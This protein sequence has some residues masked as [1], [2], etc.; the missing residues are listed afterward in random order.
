[1]K[2]G[3]AIE[4]GAVRAIFACGAFDALLSLD[5]IADH[6]V[7]VS[8]GIGD[9]V[10]YCSRQPGRNLEILEK[11]VND[12]RYM[13]S[14]NM[15]NPLNNCYFGLDFVYNQ[16]PNRLVPFDYE[17]FYA[18]PGQVEAVCTNLN[19]GRADYLDEKQDPVGFPI[20]IASCSMP[21]L[22]PIAFWDGQPY[23]DGGVADPIPYQ[24][25]LDCG[26]DRSIV[27][28]TRERSYVKKP[29]KAMLLAEQKYRDYPEFVKALKRREKVY[30]AERDEVFR[31]EKEGRI[32]VI[33]PY[34]TEGFSRTERNLEK[35]RAM[36]Q[37][38][39]DQVLA[40]KDEILAYLNS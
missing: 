20:M 29:E 19:T 17:T 14:D 6:V 3:L 18:Y 11:Y 40:R 28:L 4:G 35:I 25:L 16:I 22:F 15:I 30:N 27:I 2:T 38:G 9:G 7:G 1:M 8:A 39:Y 37:S 24:R 26:C 10:S 34:S 31:L 33:C 12:P 13:S 36:Y 5:F 21:M 23:L 32:L